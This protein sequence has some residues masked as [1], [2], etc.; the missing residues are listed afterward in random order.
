M[1][2][3]ISQYHLVSSTG[4]DSSSWFMYPRV[5]GEVERDLKLKGLHKLCLYRP[6]VLMNRPDAR[7]GE[8]VGGILPFFPKI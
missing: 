8:K 2:S 6:G 7:F 5:K 1:N 3:E 4:A